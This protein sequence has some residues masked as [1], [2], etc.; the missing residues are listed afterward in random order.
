MLTPTPP[1]SS[2][3]FLISRQGCW[4]VRGAKWLDFWQECW[5]MRASR[6][7]V[8]E[9]TTCTRSSIVH[10]YFLSWFTEFHC[11]AFVGRTQIRTGEPGGNQC[12]GKPLAWE[13][14]PAVAV[15]VVAVS[16]FSWWNAFILIFELF[17][18]VWR[19]CVDQ[20]EEWG[21]VSNAFC[22]RFYFNI[23]EFKKGVEFEICSCWHPTIHYCHCYFWSESSCSY[24]FA[25]CRYSSVGS[26]GGKQ[27]GVAAGW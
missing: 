21:G 12:E 13:N 20:S 16:M 8:C 3:R 1:N 26:V 15:A 11:A 22:R 19:Y 5:F 24:S 18:S 7:F 4:F 14:K 9:W 17:Q 23:F 25:H 6:F 27:R 2:I 10:L